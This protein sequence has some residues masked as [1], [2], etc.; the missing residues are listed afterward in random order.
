M[1]L[2][3]VAVA[4]AVALPLA[5][6]ACASAPLAFEPLDGTISGTCHT[7]MVKGAVGLAAA[8]PTLE[9]IRVDSDSTALTTGEGQQGVTEG[10]S[11]VNVQISDNNAIT[12][13]TCSGTQVAS[14]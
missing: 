9:R 6:S 2:A 1:R 13:I 5:L 12:A 8:Q 7:D 3:L 14:S 11:S 4:A 10:G